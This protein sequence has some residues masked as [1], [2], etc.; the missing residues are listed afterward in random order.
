MRRPHLQSDPRANP[1]DRYNREAHSYREL[2]APILRVAGL[3]LLREFAG[4]PVHRIVDVGTGVG[5]LLPDLRMTF[6]GAF[7]LG[8]DRSPGMLALMPTG[9]PRAV[10]D[11][12]QLGLPPASVDLVLLVFMLF[13]LKAPAD[14]L[15]EARRILR[16]GG[17]VGC[18][19]WAGDLQSPATLI[20]TECLEAHGAAEA[21]PT[22]ET[23]HEPVNT[24]AKMEAL[25]CSAGF[26]SVRCWTDELVSSIH[27]DHLIRLRTSMGSAK[28]RFDSLTVLAQ[29]ACVADARRRMEKLEPE[30][31]VARGSVVCAAADASRWADTDYVRKRNK[32]RTR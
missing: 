32:R 14:G 3:R 7:I 6:P 9:S 15:R 18:L 30:D 24:P 5:F 19:T 22:T 31:F 29:E 27:L 8:I 16:G 28:P 26:S 13:H 4:A 10:M 12:T 2:W 11:A 17:R 1:T 25:L 21:D 23:R 20:W